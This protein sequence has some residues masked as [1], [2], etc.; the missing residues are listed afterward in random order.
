[1]IDAGVFKV[2]LPSEHAEKMRDRVGQAVI[3]GVRPEDMYDNALDPA[4]GNGGNTLTATVDVIEPMGAVVYVYL[5]AGEHSLIAAL[6]AATRAAVGE[7]L[8]VALDMDH[9]HLFDPSTERA[10]V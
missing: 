9:I 1:M 10:L 2:A 4:R 6:D 5:T 7:P 3:F 8:V